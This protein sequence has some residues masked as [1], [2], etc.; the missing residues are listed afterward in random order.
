PIRAE[1]R[2]VRAR[3]GSRRSPPD[4]HDT[5]G[6]VAVV[7][8]RRHRDRIESI[9]STMQYR[10]HGRRRS[11][12]CDFRPL[13]FRD[14]T[15]MRAGGP[16]QPV[17]MRS[18]SLAVEL[19]AARLIISVSSGPLAGGPVAPSGTPLLMEASM[20]PPRALRSAALFVLLGS[21]SIAHANLV[22]NGNF[23]T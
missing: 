17:L 1:R 21:A 18:R 11:P 15:A 3:V 10:W 14:C 6:A 20:T 12:G 8:P 23:G 13:G 7:R 22:V 19:P 4:G 5:G 16:A 9:V 2:A